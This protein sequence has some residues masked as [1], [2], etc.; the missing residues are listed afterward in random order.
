M[1]L[2]KNRSRLKMGQKGQNLSRKRATTCWCDIGY[3]C[4]TFFFST[5]RLTFFW[6]IIRYDLG[7]G[8][9]LGRTCPEF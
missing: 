8:H 2:S 7:C 9:T 6:R 5:G 1:G 4:T 3:K